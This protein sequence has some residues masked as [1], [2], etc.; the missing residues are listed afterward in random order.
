[1]VGE[2][3]GSGWKKFLRKHWNI[4]AIF[5]AAGVLAFAG[6]IYVYLWLVGDAQASGLV[7]STLGLWTMA[8]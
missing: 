5:V 8:I 4:V 6:A 7:P 1:M 3:N 2:E